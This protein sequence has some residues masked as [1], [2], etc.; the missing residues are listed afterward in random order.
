[1]RC[2]T[3][4]VLSVAGWALLTLIACSNPSVAAFASTD[5]S[6]PPGRTAYPYAMVVGPDNNIWFVEWGGQ[7]VGRIT[8]AGV[9]T[10]FPIAN[11]QALLGIASGPDGNLWFTDQTAGTVGHISIS[12]TNLVQYSLGA[13]TFPEGITAGPDGNLWFVEQ[14]Q[15][16]SYR[17]GKIT[18]AGKITSYSTGINAGTFQEFPA[19]GYGFAAI[20]K[21][22][23][24]NLWFINP[25][26]GTNLQVGKITT[27]GALTL[28]PVSDL[29]LGLTS[30]P[31]GNLWLTELAHVAKLTTG[32]AETEYSPTHSPWLGIVTGPDGNL[33]FSETDSGF[34]KVVPSTGAVTEFPGMFPTF[35]FESAIVSGPDGNLWFTG[36]FSSNLGKIDTSGTLQGTFALSTGSVIAFDGLGPDGNVW[37]TLDYPANGIGKVTPTGVI[38]TYPLPTANA[39]A[40][41]ITGGPDGNVW[42]LETDVQQIAKVTTSGVVTEY[43]AGGNIFFGITTGP[44]GNIWFPYYYVKSCKCSAIGRI[45]P[46]GSISVF[47]TTTVLSFPF[48]VAVGPDGNIWFTE[49]AA[50]QIGSMST[51]GVPLAEYPVTT[52]GA[53]LSAITTGPDGNLWFLENTAYGAVGKITTAGVITEYPAQ[54]QNFQNGIVAGPDGALWF[55]EG[56]PNSVARMTAKG[57]LST[58]PLTTL[59][60][61]GNSLTVGPD[62]KIWVAEALAGGLGRLSAIGGTAINFSAA[63]GTQFSGKVASFVD[64]TPSATTSNF[65]AIINW[66]DGTTSAGTVAGKTGGPFTVTGAHTYSATGTDHFYVSFHDKVDNSTYTSTKGVATVN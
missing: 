8:T 34:A 11:A 50:N 6:V 20:I 56:Y 53:N 47:P 2:V 7:K 46:A 17:I 59:N 62:H 42:F 45:T 33:W 23:D 37:F 36:E 15:A 28:Y 26:N 52:A 18:T 5:F 41:G 1:M 24:G 40:S 61:L 13:G 54:F 19:L 58:V 29:P 10:E 43:P 31:D 12:G 22:T 30:G 9:I 4:A 63:H 39:G 21:G 27:T 38:T 49:N 48:D 57:V 32:G 3:G 51:A 60:P 64:G 65:T 66:G 14:K 55:A 44:D 25:Q 16:G 35:D